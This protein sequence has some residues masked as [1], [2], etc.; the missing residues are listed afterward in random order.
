MPDISV[1]RVHYGFIIAR[2]RSPNAGQPIPVM[3]QVVALDPERAYLR[4]DLLVHERDALAIGN[5]ESI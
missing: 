5:P 1:Q 3:E 2:E 4:P